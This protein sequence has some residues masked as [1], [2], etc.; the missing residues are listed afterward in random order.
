[1]PVLDFKEI[2]QANL[3]NG[4]Q[5]TFEMFARDF[6]IMLGFQIKEGP[7]RGQDG[8][9]D[10]II[11]E[12]R[13]GIIGNT[14]IDWLVSCKHN[15]HSGRAVLNNDEI[16]IKGRV[17][18]L[19]AK[20]FI[21]LYSTIISSPLGRT[22]DGLKRYF[23][24]KVFDRELIEKILLENPKG[25]ILAKRYFPVSFSKWEEDHPRPANIFF[26]Y[27]PLLCKN[28]GKDLLPQG[29]GIVVFKEDPETETYVAF[30]W[31]CKGECDR[32]LKNKYRSMGYVDA[33]WED[34]SDILI[35]GKYLAW[36]MA[37]L[38][39]L[40]EDIDKY[41]EEAFS[42]IKRFILRASQMVLRNQNEEQIRRLMS[43]ASLPD[44]I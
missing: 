30:L 21:G 35:P 34:I 4:L 31:C 3:A 7:D 39:R 19:G 10:L 18:A 33:G 2:T 15:A 23:D 14:E 17:E 5:D 27:E 16:D 6:F 25:K 11:T 41:N 24:V 26:E 9:R 28:C 37:I 43:L 36:N 1:M 44:Y 8:G 32:I 29:D 40:H 20:G 13:E 22:L 38:N 12:K 42:S